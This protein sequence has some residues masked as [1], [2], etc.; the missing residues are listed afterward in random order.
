VASPQSWWA[1]L[2]AVGRWLENTLLVLFFGAILVL[3]TAQIALRNGFAAGLPWADPL[4][5]LLV[6]WLAVVGAIAASRDRKHIAIE[7]VTRSLPSLGRRL[8]TAFV[9]LFTSAVTAY[10][11]WQAWRF[12]QDSKS[13]G[14][15]LF[16]TWPAWVLQ[17]VL[18]VGFA[19]IAYRY[20]V[21]ALESLGAQD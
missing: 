21:R 11:A 16:G 1:R 6:L 5:R 18:P 4:V 7:I 15:V 2:D 8:V 3:S 9:N 19:L 13:F 12:V 10:F 20:L 14:D 17:L